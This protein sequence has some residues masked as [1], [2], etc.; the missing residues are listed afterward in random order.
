MTPFWAL[1]LYIFSLKNKEKKIRVARTTPTSGLGVVEPPPWPRGGPTTPKREKKEKKK[2]GMGCG[3]G[4]GHGGGSS[5]PLGQKWGGPATPFWSRSG[6]SHSIYLF[7]NFS[8]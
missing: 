7:F 4:L 6:W 2:K 3:G 5:H 1:K 8:F